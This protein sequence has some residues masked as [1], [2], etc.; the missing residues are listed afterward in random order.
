MFSSMGAKP[1]H[2]G[3]NFYFHE[4]KQNSMEVKLSSMKLKQHQWK[5]VEMFFHIF[6]HVI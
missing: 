2:G 5:E 3:S 4:T 1:F 6:F